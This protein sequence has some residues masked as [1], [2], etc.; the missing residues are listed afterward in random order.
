[1]N[2]M[3]EFLEAKKL[4]LFMP[5]WDIIN[6]RTAKLL[7]IIKNLKNLKVLDLGCGRGDFSKI[8]AAKNDVYAVDIMDYS[9]NFKN[10][11]IKFFRCDVS[12]GLPFKNDFFDV[13][14][15]NE[16]LEHLTNLDLV[17][18]EI[19]RTLKAD[20]KLIAD[21]PNTTM[22][23]LGDI[24]GVFG[25]TKHIFYS[26]FEKRLNFYRD[27]FRLRINFANKGKYKFTK[28]FYLLFL[29]IWQMD[30]CKKEHIH[31]HSNNW[32]KDKF[33]KFN[34][35]IVREIPSCFLPIF[36]PLPEIYK[37]KIYNF[38]RH[39]EDKLIVK[40]LSTTTIFLLKKAVK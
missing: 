24:F 38:E 3:E 8:L 19:Y 10:T 12:K 23:I 16:V 29:F 15:A 27:T 18:N 17:I 14:L 30:Y 9:K 40:R 37:P 11:N 22:N 25:A 6:F 2:Y 13:I 33:K 4:D 31:K 36:I 32:W 28:I 5:M 34:F 21:V 1:M 26:S 7:A 20:G 35:D 39:N